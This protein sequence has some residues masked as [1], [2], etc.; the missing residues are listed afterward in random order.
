MT[1]QPRRPPLSPSDVAEQSLPGI[2]QRYELHCAEGGPVVVVIHHS[3]RRDLYLMDEQGD[4]TAAAITL[5]DSQA[6]TLGAIL[7]GAYF[8]PAV[9]EEIEAVVGGLVIDW[10]TL[11]DD[12]PGTG[13][14]IADLEIRR[15]T[16]MTVAAVLRD[17]VPLVAPEPTEVLCA[18]DRLVV[19]GR[20]EDL[21]GF[22]RHVVE[23]GGRSSGG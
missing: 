1:T 12:S 3:G 22:I 17:H 13:R 16:R 8:K 2:G 18:G 6:R 9:V 21:P 19:L 5:S 15:R 4:D 14:T 10:V 23:P 7:G 20:Q 11:H